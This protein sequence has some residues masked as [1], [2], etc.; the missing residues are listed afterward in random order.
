MSIRTYTLLA[1]SRQ[2]RKKAGETVDLHPSA[3]KYQIAAGVLTEMVEIQPR[4]LAEGEQLEAAPL[5]GDSTAT[6]A[7]PTEVPAKRKRGEG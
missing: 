4:E 1:D 7:G 6:D 3:A 2:Y 5:P